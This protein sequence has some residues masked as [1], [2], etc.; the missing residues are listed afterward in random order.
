MLQALDST[1]P[2]NWAETI[3]RLCNEIQRPLPAAAPP[4]PCP[5]PGMVPFRE[6]DSDRFFGREH[7]IQDMIERLRAHSVMAVVGPSG[8]C[9]SPLVLAGRSR[10]EWCRHTGTA[11]QRSQTMEL[12]HHL[13]SDTRQ[14][15][16][17]AQ[18]LFDLCHL[19]RAEQQA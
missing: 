1:D 4:P 11:E 16:Q 18:V 12:C 8:S 17:G 2:A 6:A 13:V 10:V 14:Q 5:Y 3:E 19:R 15:V 9:K 7:E